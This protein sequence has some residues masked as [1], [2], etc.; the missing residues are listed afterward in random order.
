M[1]E[2]EDPDQFIRLPPDELKDWQRRKN[3]ALSRAMERVVGHLAQPSGPEYAA[4]REA[5]RKK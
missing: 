3:A 2:D 1:G 4:R 5:L